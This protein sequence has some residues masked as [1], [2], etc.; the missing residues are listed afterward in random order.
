MRPRLLLFSLCCSLALGVAADVYRWKDAA[1][2]VYFSDTPQEGAEKVE[3]KPTTIVPSN[4]P[5]TK[6]SPEEPAAGMV[7]LPYTSVTIES[8]ANKETVR[9]TRQ[10]AVSVALE[11]AL[12]TDFGHRIQLLLDD[13]P[14]APP[15]TAGGFVLNEVNRGAHTLVAIVIGDDDGELARSAPSSFFLH[16]QTIPKPKKPPAKPPTTP[17]PPP[18]KPASS[19]PAN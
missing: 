8:P 9:N 10:V 2:N 13:A 3:L 12:Q 19:L 4:R 16:Q 1:G 7:A 15:A 18:A 11:P 17:A 6:L 14:A 5:T